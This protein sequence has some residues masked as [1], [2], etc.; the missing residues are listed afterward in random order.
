MRDSYH[1]NVQIKFHISYT[2]SK[3][4]FLFRIYHICSTRTFNWFL[5]TYGE[6]RIH[7]SIVAKNKPIKLIISVYQSCICFCF[8]FM[9]QTNV[10]IKWWYE[11]LVNIIFWLK[12]EHYY[13]CFN[14]VL[15]SF[16]NYFIFGSQCV[17]EVN[18]PAIFAY[19]ICFSW[20]F[21]S[22]LTAA[23]L[24]WLERSPRKWKV[25]CLNPNRDKPKS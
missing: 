20:S 13:Y 15:F 19:V 14:G 2:I 25:W 9:Q 7:Q 3:W 23:V 10:L 8:H 18:N 5:C 21:T 4:Y 11:N 6:H 16:L 1:L 24:Q 17:N 12:H 22:I